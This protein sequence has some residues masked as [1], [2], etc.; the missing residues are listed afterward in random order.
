MAS[1]LIVFRN[2]PLKYLFI[3]NQLEQRTCG[4]IRCARVFQLLNKV[5]KCLYLGS[6]LKI[7]RNCSGFDI[8]GRMPA[9]LSSLD[10]VDYPFE[11]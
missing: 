4:L 11:N 5:I 6:V 9:R 2:H 3:D 8:S 10:L 1:G 7:S